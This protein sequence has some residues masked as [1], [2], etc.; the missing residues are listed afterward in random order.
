M[1]SDGSTIKI[2]VEFFNLETSTLTEQKKERATELFHKW[3]HILT[4]IG[5]ASLSEHQI[6]LNNE[7]HFKEPYRRVPPNIC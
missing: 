3:K 5:R 1:D 4:D 2:P 7:E 6:L